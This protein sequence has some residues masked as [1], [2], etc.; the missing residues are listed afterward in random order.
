MF[1]YFVASNCLNRFSI[2][3]FDHVLMDTSTKLGTFSLEEEVLTEDSQN[4][5]RF[6]CNCLNCYF[7]TSRSCL[8]L[9]CFF[10]FFLPF[11]YY[12]L[13]RPIRISYIKGK[14]FKI[15]NAMVTF[16]SIEYSKPKILTWNLHHHSAS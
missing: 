1:L 11:I 16:I 5:G 4:F 12:L 7:T 13:A 8:H 9:N 2:I 10:N 3:S 6:I 14:I 15:K